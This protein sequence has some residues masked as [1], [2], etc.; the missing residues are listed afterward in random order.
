MNK[1]ILAMLL[2]VTTSSAVADWV[3][4]GANDGGDIYAH[5]ESITLKL[6]TG[7]NDMQIIEKHLSK[8]D[9]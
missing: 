7:E 9:Y 3:A 2:A 8:M 5:G 1:I 6:K 4:V